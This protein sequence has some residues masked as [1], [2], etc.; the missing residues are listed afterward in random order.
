LALTFGVRRFV[1]AMVLNAWFF[2]AVV[3]GANQTRFATAW[4]W[5]RS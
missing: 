1:V 4:S 5:S 2:V 3:L